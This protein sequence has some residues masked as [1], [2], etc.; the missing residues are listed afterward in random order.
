MKPR[1][2]QYARLG[3]PPPRLG[4][5]ST[6]W[7]VAVAKTPSYF[8]AAKLNGENLSGNFLITDIWVKRDGAW[9]VAAG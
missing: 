3:G 7:E 6:C 2:P 1:K 4:N 9:K 5:D 8:Q